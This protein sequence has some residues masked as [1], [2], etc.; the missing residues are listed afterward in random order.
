M[1]SI[2]WTSFALSNIHM[3]AAASSRRNY[4]SSLGSIVLVQ[5]LRDDQDPALAVRELVVGRYHMWA[6]PMIDT[7]VTVDFVDLERPVF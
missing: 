7:Y 1:K 2:S 4:L 5:L 6:T 3:Q